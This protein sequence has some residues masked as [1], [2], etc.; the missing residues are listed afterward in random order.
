MK[1]AFQSPAYSAVAVTPSDSVNLVGEVKSLFI[2]GAGNVRVLTANGE[3]VIFSGMSAGSYL[4]VQVRR[5][6]ATSTTATN[7][8]ALY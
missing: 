5:V 2:G 6:F 4:L 1:Y 8:V 3:T 7:I